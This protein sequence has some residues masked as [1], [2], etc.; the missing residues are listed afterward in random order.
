MNTT[1]MSGL[2]SSR[3]TAKSAEGGLEH[4]ESIV[5]EGIDSHGTDH[6]IILD[7]KDKRG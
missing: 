5:L 2:D 4:P 1:P 6:G 3:V 7:D